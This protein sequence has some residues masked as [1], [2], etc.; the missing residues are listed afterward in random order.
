MPLRA[1]TL[2]EVGCGGS[3]IAPHEDGLLYVIRTRRECS[4]PGT[5]RRRAH[6]GDRRGRDVLLGSNASASTAIVVACRQCTSRTRQRRGPPPSIPRSDP[7]MSRGL[8]DDRSPTHLS[9]RTVSTTRCSGSCCNGH[10]TATGS[11]R[12]P[13]DPPHRRTG[14]SRCR[15]PLHKCLRLSA[16]V[17]PCRK[18]PWRGL[19]RPPTSV[20][21]APPPPRLVTCVH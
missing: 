15:E 1:V 19:S 7:P 14:R 11:R 13:P 9:R 12:C 16:A 17:A 3:S 4:A 20:L 10:P 2:V 8:K 5:S 6:A 18:R 21:Q